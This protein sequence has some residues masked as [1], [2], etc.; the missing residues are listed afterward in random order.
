MFFNE[1][2]EEGH[3]TKRFER[4]QLMS[5]YV[6]P[7]FVDTITELAGILRDRPGDVDALI[8]DFSAIHPLADKDIIV[9]S[10]R[11]NL[12]CSLFSA[13]NFMSIYDTIAADNAQEGE[14]S[15]D[16]LFDSFLENDNKEVQDILFNNKVRLTALFTKSE[17]YKIWEKTQSVKEGMLP[18]FSGIATHTETRPVFNIERTAIDRFVVAT[19][20]SIS[21][22]SSDRNNSDNIIIELKEEDLDSILQEM[23]KAKKKVGILSATLGVEKVV[24]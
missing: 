21:F 20:L 4:L 12:Q 18:C 19:T 15:F 2:A 11:D 6:P 23:D 16:L 10:V 3:N 22:L 5:F 13:G 7:W 17:N 8:K 1:G 9:G 24:K 14:R